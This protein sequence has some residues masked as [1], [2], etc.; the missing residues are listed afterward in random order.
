MGQNAM[1]IEFR[2]CFHECSKPK[3]HVID[4]TIKS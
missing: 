2:G 3:K 4:Y 1:R